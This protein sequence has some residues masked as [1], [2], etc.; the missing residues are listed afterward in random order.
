MNETGYC[1]LFCLCWEQSIFFV[2]SCTVCIAAVSGWTIGF[3][4]LYNGAPTASQTDHR[5]LSVTQRGSVS[6][7]FFLYIIRKLG[8]CQCRVG[9]ILVLKIANYVEHLQRGLEWWS[10]HAFM[11]WCLIKQHRNNVTPVSRGRCELV[12]TCSA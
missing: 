12:S 4:S 9:F 5:T 1:F 8:I 3:H 11:A 7:F 10:L 6:G 2:V